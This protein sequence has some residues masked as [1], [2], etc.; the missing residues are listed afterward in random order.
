MKQMLGDILKKVN[1]IPSSAAFGVLNGEK[2]LTS[3]TFP[4]FHS[5]SLTIA[6]HPSTLSSVFLFRHNPVEP[7]MHRLFSPFIQHVSYLCDWAKK[8]SKYQFHQ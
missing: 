3:I 8:N 2:N 6:F 7:A 1:P 5:A 4:L